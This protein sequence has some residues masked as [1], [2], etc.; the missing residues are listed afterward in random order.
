MAT[1]EIIVNNKS[2]KVPLLDT[3]GVV[4]DVNLPN[5]AQRQWFNTSSTRKL[6]TWYVN[7]NTEIDVFAQTDLST[8]VNFMSIQL[9]KGSTGDADFIFYA[10]QHSSTATKRFSQKVTIPAGWSWKLITGAGRTIPI[11]YELRRS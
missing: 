1:L 8:S 4:L 5:Q 3:N 6:D 11:V 7:G 10:D 9:R 2:E